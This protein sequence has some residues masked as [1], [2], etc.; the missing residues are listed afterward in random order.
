LHH[1]TQTNNPTVNAPA[2]R[3]LQH[4]PL[5]AH[6]RQRIRD[7]HHPDVIAVIRDAVVVAGLGNQHPVARGQAGRQGPDALNKEG[8]LAAALP[9][10]AAVGSVHQQSE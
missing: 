10:H 1:R 6:A 5:A 2:K 7:L 3:V 8:Q 9:A 4:Q